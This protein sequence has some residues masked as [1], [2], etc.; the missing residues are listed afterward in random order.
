[1]DVFLKYGR[2][3]LKYQCTSESTTVE[4]P[5]TILGVYCIAFGAVFIVDSSWLV[6]TNNLFTVTSTFALYFVFFISFL[7]KYHSNNSYR[8]S[9]YEKQIFLQSS[10]ICGINLSLALI[11]VYMMYFPVTIATTIAGLF[12][13][14]LSS[15]GAVVVY[16]GVNKTVRRKVLR[17]IPRRK[18]ATT[19]SVYYRIIECL[20]DDKKT[21]PLRATPMQVQYQ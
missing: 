11:Y 10:A 3:P 6:A 9:S 4:V 1:M 18:K 12:L 17:M 8:I 7:Y 20:V 14:Q 15:A 5:N 2:L 19:V 21:G 13:W 16:I